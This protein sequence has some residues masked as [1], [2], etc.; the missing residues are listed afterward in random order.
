[1]MR[2]GDF[3]RMGNVSVRTLR[4][5]AERRLLQP[6][7]V[8]PV[9]GYRHYQANQLALLQQI[10]TFQDLGF[11]LAAIRELLRRDLPPAELRALMEQRCSDLKRRIRGDLAR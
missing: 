6:V 4:F 2:I 10:R 1:M 11:S 5:Y 8:D 3:A 9:S 7:L